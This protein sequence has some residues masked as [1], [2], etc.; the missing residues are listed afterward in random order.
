MIGRKGAPRGRPSSFRDDRGRAFITYRT[1]RPL[2][3]PLYAMPWC[4]TIG[5]AMPTVLAVATLG[6]C[7]FTALA[8]A[9]T[10]APPPP[11]PEKTTRG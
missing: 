3:L 8:H 9:Q 10:P 5:P 6:T 1:A 7:A 11:S 2:I 4:C